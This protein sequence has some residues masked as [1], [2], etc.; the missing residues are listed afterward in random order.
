[1]KHSHIETL[2]KEY[3]GQRIFNAREDGYSFDVLSDTWELGYKTYLYLNWIN[4]L[5]IDTNTYLDLR[6]AIAHTA[7]HYAYGTLYR[8]VSSLKNILAHLNI[9]DF[10]A[11][12]LTLDTYK[13][14]VR[15]C[16]YALCR[17]RSNYT[18]NTLQPLYDAVREEGITRHNAMKGILDQKTGAYSEV[19]H[20]NI[21]ESIRIKTLQVLEGEILSQKKF[22]V[23]RNIIGSQLLLALIRRPTQLVQLKWCDILPVGETFLTHKELN[24][25]WKPVTQHLFSD[26]EQLHVRTFKGKDGKF[27]N[28]AESRS[29]RLDPDLS[30]L[31]LRYF[32]VY[33]NYLLHSLSTQHISLDKNET[34][35][36]MRRLPVLPDQG[37]FSSY[38]DSKAELFIS[39]S[40][41]SKAYHM[42]SDSLR[43]N[44]SYLF[45]NK[46]K[47]NS[48]RRP[49]DSLQLG[50]NR[51]RHTILTKG[52]KYGL[53]PAH[54]AAMTGVTIG[55]IVPYLDLK[56]S[57]RVKI[58]EA[59]AGNHIIKRFD[60]LSVKELQTHDD[61][62]VKS[63][64]DEEIG[65]KINPANC[66]SCQSKGGAPMACYPCDNFRPLEMANHYQYLDKAER[67]LAVNSQSAHPATVK[68]L[69][70]IILYIKATITICEERKIVKLGDKE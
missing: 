52:A 3:D 27:R 6:L 34:K 54:L 21:L 24:L 23:L 68:R 41:T 63:S 55:A 17:P 70:K 45:E 15:D 29:H 38:F 12:W 11:W 57:E 67:K 50:N 60:S 20:D 43:S 9:Q 1:M 5:H 35:E 40:D 39:T 66:S 32:Q 59:Y 64:F 58:D 65:H 30:Q 46:L 19:E 36:L 18:C 7:K 48:D 37:L 47:P 62:K 53:S 10:Q 49:N 14:N 2:E 4:E 31:L 25:N 8:H 13:K 28:N 56:A 51:W 61:F 26:V 42:R 44:I 16:L 33:E 69:K 22:T